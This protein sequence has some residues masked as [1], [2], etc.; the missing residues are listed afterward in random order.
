M[1]A[2]LTASIAM[3]PSPWME[4][5]R[6]TMTDP[7]STEIDCSATIVMVGG[8]ALRSTLR[9]RISRSERPRDRS[10]RTNSCEY[11]EITELR[12]CCATEAMEEI[13][14]AVTGRSRPRN[15]WLGDVDNRV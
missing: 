13:A 14:N 9:N 4:K 6:S 5:T 7:P 10:V 3:L 1:S 8:D 12:N 11:T 2:L 15:H